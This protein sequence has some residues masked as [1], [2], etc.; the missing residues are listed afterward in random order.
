LSQR[1]A[2]ES[3]NECPHE[4]T[5]DENDHSIVVHKV[6]SAQPASKRAADSAEVGH[7]SRSRIRGRREEA[8]L[9]PV[10]TASAGQSLTCWP[11]SPHDSTWARHIRVSPAAGESQGGGRRAFANA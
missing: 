10:L 5:R 8:M 1:H 7:S 9:P 4:I 6:A 3:V 2:Q 11:I